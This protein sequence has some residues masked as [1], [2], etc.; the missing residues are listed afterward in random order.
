M[1][2]SPRIDVLVVGAGAAGIGMGVALQHAGIENVLI[3]DRHGV[4]AS[5]ERWPREMSFLTPS[6]PTNSI[7]MLDLNSIAIGTSPAYTLVREHPTGKEYARYLKTVAKYFKLW[8]E[9]GLDV[10]SVTASQSGFRVA[11]SRGVLR[12]PYVV[13]AAGELQYP[14]TQPFPGA[15]YCRHTSTVQSWR[16]HAD[17]AA[18][19]IGGAESGID[20][21]IQL[22]ALQKRVTVL[23]REATWENSSSDPSV[24]LSTYTHER[25]DSVLRLGGQITPVGGVD[26]QSVVERDGGYQIKAKGRKTWFSASPPYLATGFRGSQSLVE[27]LFESRDDGFPR[28]TADDESTLVPRLFFSGPMVRHEQHVFCF[29]YKFR[30]RF[31]VV[32]KAIASRMGLAAEE[33]ETYRKWGMYLDDLSCCGEECA[34]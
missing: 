34:C 5:F 25:L 12:A 29:I 15:E 30:Q 9:K 10:R 28:L 33:L 16:D 8:I 11:T 31:A 14:Q 22:A 6:F 1:A 7:G 13:W 19:I 3:V 20:A 2:D 27:N 32:A 26:V 24:T 21:A 18:I 4:G 23:A 17:D